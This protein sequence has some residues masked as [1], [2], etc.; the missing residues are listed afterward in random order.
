[1]MRAC[2]P[3]FAPCAGLLSVLAVAVLTQPSRVQGQAS[4]QDRLENGYALL[5]DGKVDEGRSELL[6]AAATL[7]PS[8]ATPILRLSR[9]LSGLSP[10]GAEVAARAAGRS[11]DGKTTSAVSRL[12][13]DLESITVAERPALL[14][15]GAR[16]SATNGDMD[17]ASEL[18]YRIAADHEG[19]TEWPEAVVRL[20]ERRVETGVGVDEAAELL[21]SL[22]VSQPS[23][24]LAP[25]ARRVLERLQAMSA[26]ASAGLK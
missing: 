4:P 20:G 24:A 13:R 22:I 8:E 12:L 6:T 18:W 2:R 14:L 3:S 23:A 10:E 26:S 1:M 19:A 25:A 17:R 5:A 15:L 11:H 9:L 16:L 7:T 21:E